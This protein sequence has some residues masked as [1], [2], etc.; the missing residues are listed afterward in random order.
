MPTPTIEVRNQSTGITQENQVFFLTEYLKFL[1]EELL[2]QRKQKKRNAVHV[3]PP[4]ITVSHCYKKDNCA[5]TLMQSME[6]F[7]K[8]S[9]II[10]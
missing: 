3:E 7:Y 10:I 1:S 4:D 9:R 6:P 8:V 2:W 5:N